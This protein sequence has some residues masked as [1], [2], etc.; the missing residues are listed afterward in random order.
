MY[1][2]VAP[3]FRVQSGKRTPLISCLQITKQHIFIR[4]N[5]PLLSVNCQRNGIFRVVR[6]GF[7]AI[8]KA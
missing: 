1:L 5:H 3:F 6:A 4:V 7:N 2:K 8:I